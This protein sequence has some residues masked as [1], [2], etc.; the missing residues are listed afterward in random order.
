ME[1]VRH[2]NKSEQWNKGE[3]SV[4]KTQRGSRI[5]IWTGGVTEINWSRQYP[6]GL[7]HFTSLL[8]TRGKKSLT[9]KDQLTVCV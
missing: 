2:K 7:P 9:H 4:G 6:S 1:Y 5:Y 3:I 8:M